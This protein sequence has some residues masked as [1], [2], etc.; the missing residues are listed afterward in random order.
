ML[1]LRCTKKVLE[2]FNISSNDL[3][4][5]VPT[6]AT[7]GNWYVNIATID[8]RKTI[9]FMSERT[10]LSFLYFGIRKRNSKSLGEIFI[11]GLIQLLELEGFTEN[12][13]SSAIGSDRIMTITKTDNRKALGN[14]NDL[15]RI[16]EHKIWY[17]HGFKHC[18]LWKIIS[19]TNR[20][21]QKNI[22]WSYSID[23]AKELAS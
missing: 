2:Q 6:E 9:I 17:D 15:I 11:Q 18:D 22:G 4:D 10:L 23:L 16:Y 12:Q 7:L 20:M 3:F 5:P 21:P 19:S 13:I 14:M 8:R 1:Q